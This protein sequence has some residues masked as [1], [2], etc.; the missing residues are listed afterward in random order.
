[1]TSTKQRIYRGIAEILA[2]M[3]T[4]DSARSE[5]GQAMVNQVFDNLPA[6]IRAAYNTI[7]LAAAE[8]EVGTKTGD[9]DRVGLGWSALDDGMLALDALRAK[10]AD[11]MSQL[12]QAR[13]DMWEAVRHHIPLEA[14]QQF[15]SVMTAHQ[16]I[17]AKLASGGE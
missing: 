6:T 14:R 15:A 17:L 7:T 16:N 1:M 3:T 2:G 13:K 10:D 5:Q 8:I 9:Y 12:D 11:L 4:G